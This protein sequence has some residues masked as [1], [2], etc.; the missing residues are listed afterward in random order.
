MGLRNSSE[1]SYERLTRIF[2]D[3]QRDR[4][5]CRQADALIV[6]GQTVE[7]LNENL[8]ETFSRLRDCGLTIKPS[9]LIIC[10]ESTVLFGWE[11]KNQAWR[12]TAHKTNPLVSATPPATVKQLRA[13][14]GASKQLSAGLKDY[15]KVFQPLERLC[16]GRPSAERLPWPTT[17]EKY[18]QTGYEE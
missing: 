3:M 10:P 1:I 9:K 17:D 8:Q 12:P 6:G 4:R 16:A 14:L 15:A 18:F 7:A 2:G 11:F 13:W 5:L